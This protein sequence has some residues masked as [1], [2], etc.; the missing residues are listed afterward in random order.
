MATC[1]RHPS[2]GRDPDTPKLEEGIPHAETIVR[3]V[4][5]L[6]LELGIP[7]EI[8]EPAIV[9]VVGREQPP[10]AMQ[11]EHRRAVRML[12]GAHARIPRHLSALL[13]VARRARG[14]DVVPPRLPA[15]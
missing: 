3:S 7:V 2:V 4:G 13:K 6:R 14:D 8:V 11:L 12:I 15:A 9:Q 10:V 1:P 5:P